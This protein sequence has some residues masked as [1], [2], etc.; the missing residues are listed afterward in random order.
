MVT[1]KKTNK[2]FNRGACDAWWRLR[3]LFLP[4]EVAATTQR[5]HAA[6]CRSPDWGGSVSGTPAAPRRIFALTYRF[7]DSF[8]SVR[9]AARSFRSGSVHLPI[10]PSIRQSV[11]PSVHPSAQLLSVCLYV[12]PSGASASASGKVRHTIPDQRTWRR[13]SGS[14]S[15]HREII[16]AFC[17]RRWVF[18]RGV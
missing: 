2:F 12:Q 7:G 4:L 9:A 18:I 16:F 10:H 17:C 5:A 14:A 3:D 1:L 8:I 11:R 15:H 6:A 13:S